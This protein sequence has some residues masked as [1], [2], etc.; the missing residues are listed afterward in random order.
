MENYA[1]FKKVMMQID[2]QW[3]EKLSNTQCK[4]NILL[5]SI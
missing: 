3:N 2:A 4:S 5:N 1:M